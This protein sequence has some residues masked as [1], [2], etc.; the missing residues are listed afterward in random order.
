MLEYQATDT[1]EQK[2][3]NA[4]LRARFLAFE[5]AANFVQ[6]VHDDMVTPRPADPGARTGAPAGISIAA[7]SFAK[8]QAA[9][10]PGPSSFA[11]ENLGRRKPCAAINCTPRNFGAKLRL[12]P[13]CHRWQASARSVSYV[14]KNYWL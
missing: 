1:A 14:S 10:R 6:R 5:I 2:I 9:S 8:A 4:A 13:P 12:T 11:D 7:R 3:A